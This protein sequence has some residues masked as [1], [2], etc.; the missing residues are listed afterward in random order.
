[1][2]SPTPEPHPVLFPSVLGWPSICLQPSEFSANRE[3][4][5][6]ECF[7]QG[8]FPKS[9]SREMESRPGWAKEQYNNAFDI[10]RSILHLHIFI[11]VMVEWASY[12]LISSDFPIKHSAGLDENA[13][14]QSAPSP[15]QNCTSSTGSTTI[16]STTTSTTHLSWHSPLPSFSW[17]QK[18][19][20]DHDAECLCVAAKAASTCGYWHHWLWFYKFT[21]DYDFINS[22]ISFVLLKN[23]NSQIFQYLIIRGENWVILLDYLDFVRLVILTTNSM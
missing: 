15:L 2:H 9:Q 21:H 17:Y 16:S 11:T 23:I 8:M 7:A 4:F 22:H 6:K 12:L 20:S 19:P 18:I 10:R 14:F 5:E 1:M 13:A 3:C